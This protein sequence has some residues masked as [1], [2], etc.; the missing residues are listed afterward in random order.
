MTYLQ[1]VNKVLLRLRK[2]QA[3]TVADTLYTQLIGEFVKQALAEVESAWNWNDLRTTVQVTTAALDYSYSLTG[4][5]GT[6]NIIDV[7][8][9]TNDICLEKAPTSSWMTYRLLQN[10][11]PA[12]SPRYY[13]V[14][15]QTAGGLPIVNLWP[16]P[17]GVYNV[18]FN[19]CAH[20]VITADADTVSDRYQLPVVLRATM[21][22]IEERGDDGGLSL[23]YLQDQYTKALGDAISYDEALHD[24][25]STWYVN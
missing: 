24:E 23:Q 14:N 11:Q 2:T 7:L 18:N 12:A 25:E 10:N 4:V 6:F 9:D 16:I 22:A 13:D 20:T 3:A 1:L 19:V 8:E 17:D 5:T 15:G 21:H